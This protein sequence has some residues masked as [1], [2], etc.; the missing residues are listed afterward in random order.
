MV[1]GHQ[2]HKV[3]L[4]IQIFL[5][6]VVIRPITASL[7]SLLSWLQGEEVADLVLRIIAIVGLGGDTSDYIIVDTA[8]EGKSLSLGY[9]SH[10]PP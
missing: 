8:N 4:C 2:A 1:K 10:R 3:Q 5:I 6:Y 7:H 9:F